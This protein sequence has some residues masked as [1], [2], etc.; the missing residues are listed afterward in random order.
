MSQFTSRY[1]SAAGQAAQIASSGFAPLP[2]RRLISLSGADTAK[3]LQGL[4]TNNVDPDRHSSFYSAFLDA[5]GRVLWDVFVWV[6]PELVAE[7]GHWA[8]YIEV[9]GGEME[10]LKKHLKRHKLRS[11]IQIEDVRE[12]EVRV[13]AAWGSAAGQANTGD[14]I[15]AMKDPRAPD[16]H[17]CLSS[18]NA[19]TIVEGAEP[20]DVQEYHIQRYR[21][22]I[23]EGQAEIPRESALPMECNVDLSQGIDFKKGCYVGQE[24]T[25]RTKHTGIVRKRILPVELYTAG[26][27]S[28]LPEHGTDIKQLDESGSIKKGR[29]AGK[30]VA[31]IGNVGLAMCRLE[32]MTHMKV[33]AEGGTWKPGMEF[34]CETQDGVVKVKP[35]LYDWFVLR[36]R[37]LWDKNRLRL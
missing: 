8:C 35:L 12:D 29:A 22:G 33:S 30:F 7:K 10:A 20:L 36:E 16:M 27:L 23:P 13:W 14:L 21:N 1:S 37:E 34:G 26:T 2:H 19:R 11:K 15:A 28:A 6:W 17:R 3:F 5:R 32:N 24:L 31:G 9:D 25:I 4:I 18:A